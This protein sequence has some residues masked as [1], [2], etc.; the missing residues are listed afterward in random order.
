MKQAK[1]LSNKFK[2]VVLLSPFW[3]CGSTFLSAIVS[4]QQRLHNLSELYDQ[5]HFLDRN[6]LQELIFSK[7]IHKGKDL[8]LLRKIRRDI[9]IYSRDL[10]I[11]RAWHNEH[12]QFFDFDKFYQGKA[13]GCVFKIHGEQMHAFR[14]L[15]QDPSK[16]V[17]TYLNTRNT[18]LAILYR[19][20]LLETMISL[21][22]AWLH[23]PHGYTTSGMPGYYKNNI[24]DDHVQFA[25]YEKIKKLVIVGFNCILPVSLNHWNNNIGY[26]LGIK[27]EFHD[28]IEYNDLKNYKFIGDEFNPYSKNQYY[29]Q[30]LEEL[31]PIYGKKLVFEDYKFV[32]KG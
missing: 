31:R 20:D 17:S 7:K 6:E 28:I 27:K 24:K 2:N 12:R 3:R 11:N 15:C 29:Y 26:F 9:E 18:G 8:G 14:H 10:D 1:I 23:V 32:I 25:D 5:N 19:Q 4:K 30:L 22:L 16:K 13:E 21:A